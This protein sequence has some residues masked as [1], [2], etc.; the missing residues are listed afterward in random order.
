[1]KIE[2]IITAIKETNLTH[3]TRTSFDYS[4][5][6]GVRQSILKELIRR[7]GNE[8]HKYEDNIRGPHEQKSISRRTDSD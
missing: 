7:F 5:A 1:M 3:H 6:E 4:F 8:K 2:D